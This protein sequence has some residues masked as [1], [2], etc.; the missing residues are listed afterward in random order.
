[1]MLKMKFK[2]FK[3]P[4]Y[5]WKTDNWDENIETSEM[6]PFIINGILYNKCFSEFM[7]QSN[8]FIRVD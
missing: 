1:M 7:R 5:I 3:L 4:P 2:E 8:S 6:S